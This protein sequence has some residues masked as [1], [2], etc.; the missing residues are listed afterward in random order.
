MISRIHGTVLRRELGL[1]EVMTAGGVAYEVVIPLT[2]YERLP[3]E[4]SAVE[5]RTHQLFRED[6]VELFGFLEAGERAVF[7]RLLTASG[8]G[9]RLALSMLSAL[10]PERLIRA[11]ADRDIV[12]LR[13]IP[14][15]GVKKA[16]RL[17][18]ELG[19]RIDDLAATL[20]AG[21][22]PKGRAADEALGA[23]VALGYGAG[24]AAGAVRG[25]LDDDGAL[26]GA[27]L[28]KAALARLAAR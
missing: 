25:A 21:P 7:S 6:A 5:L 27:A 18:L 22:R 20:A 12:A 3:A 11:I 24:D 9:P 1:V 13:Q 4:G 28:I 14:G 8:V 17:A 23:L 10:P 19:D 26:A 2:V 16:E 15:L